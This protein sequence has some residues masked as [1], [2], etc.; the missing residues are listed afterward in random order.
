MFIDSTM[1]ALM[2]KLKEIPLEKCTYGCR[3]IQE[4]AKKPFP[5]SKVPIEL[6]V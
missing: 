5:Q 1:H 2:D 6:T 4:K 3:F